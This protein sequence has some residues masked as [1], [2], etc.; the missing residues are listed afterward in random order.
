MT[1]VGVGTLLRVAD[2]S[3]TIYHVQVRQDAHEIA[4][5]AGIVF[6]SRPAL[7]AIFNKDSGLHY[8]IKVCACAP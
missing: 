4:E 8:R 5:S 7:R 2:N 3:I 6:A 1:R